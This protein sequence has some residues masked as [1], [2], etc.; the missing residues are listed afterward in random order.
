MSTPQ[1]AILAVVAAALLA[2]CAYFEPAKAKPAPLEPIAAPIAGRQVWSQRTGDLGA[3]LLPAVSAAAVTVASLDGR[4]VAYEADS[5]RELWRGDAGAKL[6]AGV[7]SDGRWSAVVTTAN[8]LVVLDAGKTTWRARLGTR[9]V[10]PPL[11][12]GERVFVLGVD[13]SLHAYDAVDG[14]KLWA[15]QRPGDPLTL[16]QPGVLMAWKDTLVAGQGAKLA[17]FDPLRGALRW[18][19]TVASP[20]GANEVERLADLVGPAARVADTLC[21]RGFQSAIGCVDAARGSL[22]WAKNAAGA[23]GIT[24]DADYVFAADG[25]GRIQAWKTANGDPAWTSERLLYRGLSAPLVV[26]RTLVFGDAEGLLHF[27]DRT[28]GKPLLRLPT[29]GRP[30]VAAPVRVGTTLVAVTQGGGVY[31][32]RPE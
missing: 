20:R 17:G 19:A 9:V 29:D 22:V 31:A 16:L 26:G 13:R 30:I 18:E 25:S 8:E 24:A 11:V 27:L 32:F 7:G 10:T 14:R 23:T 1:R 6:S 28:D 15:Q 12:A 3:L 2:G 5:G 4:V 21:A